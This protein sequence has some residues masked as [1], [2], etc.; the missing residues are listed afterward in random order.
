MQFKTILLG[1]A[2]ALFSVTA[3][4]GT[5]HSHAPAASKTPVSQASAKKK[6]TKIVASHVKRNKLDKSWATAKL[7][8]IKK[9]TFK[10]R[11]EWVVM[12][13]NDKV[14]DKAK[15]KLYVFMTLNGEY[16]AAN[17]TGK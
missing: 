13:V 1:S 12:F 8:T 15:Q 16:I 3:I 2:L 11:G 17:F 4:A 7:S 14:T 6:A 10:G 9:R 5:G